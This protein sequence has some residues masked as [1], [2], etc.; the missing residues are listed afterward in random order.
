[1]GDRLGTSWHR[2][3]GLAGVAAVC[4]IAFASAAG[5][6]RAAAATWYVAPWGSDGNSCSDPAQP[7]ATINSAIGKASAGDTIEV[8]VGIYTSSGDPVVLVNKSLT[9]AG[10]WDST[11]SSRTGLSIV[12]GQSGRASCRERV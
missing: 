8:A 9:L 7:C 6:A 10:G 1:M 11:F 2:Y 5:L 12:D 3:G 4:L